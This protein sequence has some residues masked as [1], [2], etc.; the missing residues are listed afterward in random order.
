MIFNPTEEIIL[1][2]LFLITKFY[3]LKQELLVT[4]IYVIGK[5]YNGDELSQVPVFHHIKT[6]KFEKMSFIDF[7]EW[8]EELYLN[9]FEYI[10]NINYYGLR[11]CF[12]PISHFWLSKTLFPIYPWNE[13]FMAL[14]FKS[15]I[16]F[17]ENVINEYEKKLKKIKAENLYLKKKIFLKKKPRSI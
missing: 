1:K 14:F 2:N 5:N 8:Y 10:K 13:S 6:S 7:V 11:F 3:T 12:L 15:K 9:D 4:N 17:T 16:D